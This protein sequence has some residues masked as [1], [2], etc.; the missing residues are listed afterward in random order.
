MQSQKSG[1]VADS[2]PV[3]I[4]IEPC[5]PV[6][7]LAEDIHEGLLE[8]PRWLPPKYF[9]DEYGANLFDRIC[10][11]PEYYP[12]R[13]EDGM[14]RQ[15]S[16]EIISVTRPDLIVELGSGSSR[17]TRRLFDACEFLDHS[18]DYAPFDVCEPMI[19]QTARELEEEYHWLRTMPLLGDYHAGLKNLPVCDDNNLFVF[20]GSTIGNFA[21]DERKDFLDDLR[22][23]MNSGDF[24]L[25]GA[26]RVKDPNILNA[27]YND[28]QGITAEFNLNLLRVLNREAGSNFRLE[29]F[30]HRAC[31][32]E[33]Q[34]RIE[35]HLLALE[36]QDIEFC[37]LQVTTQIQRGESIL[38]EISR[39]FQKQEIEQALL[40][41]RL[42]IVRHFEASEAWFS[43]VLA[44]AN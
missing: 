36:N 10:D 15:H 31:Y 41:S 38:T 29:D 34:R 14:L 5:R 25:V 16:E 20:L 21:E 27:A 9:Y 17:K 44:R 32:N 42:E 35:M 2:G 28:S 8:D 26:D 18:C 19:L 11:T 4:E 12:T 6:T 7:S 23:C 24:L 22:Q 40:G 30:Q 1:V 43:L 37:E 33:N 39:K 3:C 13:I